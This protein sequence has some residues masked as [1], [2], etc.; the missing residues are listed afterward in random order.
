MPEDVPDD[1]DPS[2]VGKAVPLPL[3]PAGEALAHARAILT[4]GDPTAALAALRCARPASGGT[5]AT[6]LRPYLQ[7]Q[8]LCRVAIAADSSTI[9]AWWDAFGLDA[10]TASAAD[11]RRQ[12]RRLSALVHPDKGGTAEAFS[13]LQ[14]GLDALLEALEPG[15]S[16]AKRQ[17]RQDSG[18]GDEGE[19]VDD[20]FAWWTE[21]DDLGGGKVDTVEKE[22]KKA[23][24]E[25]DIEELEKMDA[26]TL[27]IEVRARQGALLGALPP[28][29]TLQDLK[30]ALWRARAALNSKLQAAAADADAATGGGFLP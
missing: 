14:D 24:E 23:A 25:A 27:A 26:E 19:D 11:T 15:Q 4:K 22:E 18:G 17:R 9:D 2:A 13:Q 30:A 6:S 7:L 5:D 21:W 12:F 3:G 20:E 28:G 16:S 10:A 29:T 1:G 8:A